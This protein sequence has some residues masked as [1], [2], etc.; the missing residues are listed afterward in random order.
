MIDSQATLEPAQASIGEGL[1]AAA[2]WKEFGAKLQR[3]RA[4]TVGMS[5]QEPSDR[6]LLSVVR[7]REIELGLGEP[8]TDAEIRAYCEALDFEAEPF[9]R[10]AAEIREGAR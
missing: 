10:R 1:R 4:F 5:R 7:I 6:S 2:L 9:A 8:P 3:T